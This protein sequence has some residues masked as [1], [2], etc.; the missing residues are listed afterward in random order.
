MIVYLGSVKT[1]CSFQFNA[2]MM[3]N[4]ILTTFLV[5]EITKKKILEFQLKLLICQSERGNISIRF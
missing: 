5:G 4:H 3:K 1:F 2:L